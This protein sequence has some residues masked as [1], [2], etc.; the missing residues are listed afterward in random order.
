MRVSPPRIT[1][2]PTPAPKPPMG[3]PGADAYRQAGFVLGGDTALILD[4]LTLEGAVAAAS[5]DAKHRTQQLAAGMGQWSRSWLCRQQALHAVQSGNYAAAFP[6]V[7]AAADYLA[8]EVALLRTGAAEWQG[9]L[10]TGGIAQA[11]E[12]HAMEFRLHAFRSAESL[13]SLPELGAL[14]RQASDLALSHFGTT[15]LLAGNESTP[16][17]VLMTFGDRDFHLGLAELALGFLLTLGAVQG[18]T[19]REF[20]AVFNLPDA[21]ALEAH[22][23]SARALAA[24]RDRCRMETTELGGETRY[25]VSNWRRQSGAAPK[26]VLL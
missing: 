22:A 25:L 23:A 5:A 2:D 15:L 9:W 1:P 11:P 3:A 7:R 20:E 8:A 4:G 18:D 17:R 24:G 12:A 13:A 14:Y 19:L 26:R 16:D 10:D 6:L 21:A